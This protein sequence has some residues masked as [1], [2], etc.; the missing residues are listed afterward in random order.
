MIITGVVILYSSN[1]HCP[2][3]RTCIEQLRSQ[4]KFVVIKPLSEIKQRKKPAA[5]A[6]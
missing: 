2:Q 6:S 4:G 3:Q 5:G 1:P